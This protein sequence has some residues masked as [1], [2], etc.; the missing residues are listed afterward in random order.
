DSNGPTPAPLTASARAHR[1]GWRRG[2]EPTDSRSPPHERERDPRS[3][4]ERR[5]EQER[6]GE[7]VRD[8]AVE[9]ILETRHER[10]PVLVVARTIGERPLDVG[11]LARVV[12]AID[13]CEH[14]LGD[15]ELVEWRGAAVEHDGR[16][17]PGRPPPGPPP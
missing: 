17:R 6:A 2:R 16:S 10:L 13:F 15:A 3:E 8:R 9:L 1:G 5:R 14:V 7:R 4:G 11:E 12:G